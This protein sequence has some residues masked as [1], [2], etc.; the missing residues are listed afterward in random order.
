MEEC[1][2]DHAVPDPDAPQT[3]HTVALG[4]VDT[5]RHRIGVTDHI[6]DIIERA[7]RE[8]APCPHIRSSGDSNWCALAEQQAAT[9]ESS[10]AQPDPQVLFSVTLAGSNAIRWEDVIN[11]LTIAERTLFDLWN[12]SKEIDDLWCLRVADTAYPAFQVVRNL[13]DECRRTGAKGAIGGLANP[14]R[15]TPRPGPTAPKVGGLLRQVQIALSISNTGDVW[16]FDLWEKQIRAV[17]LIAAGWLRSEGHRSA[18]A[19]LERE[20]Q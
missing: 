20:V 17:I 14:P 15:I 13:M 7:I 3:L 5:L 18:A 6:C 16:E 12:A 1:G 9:E 4:M 19:L 2:K 8:P 10:A 11:A